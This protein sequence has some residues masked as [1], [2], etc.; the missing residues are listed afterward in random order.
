ML[1]VQNSVTVNVLDTPDVTNVNLSAT[2]VTSVVIDKDN[3]NTIKGG[4]TLKAYDAYGN[5]A[6]LVTKD[7]GSAIGIGVLSTG[8]K[9]T[10][11][12]NQTYS[13]DPTEL[14]VKLINGAYKSE[15]IAIE[16]DKRN[17]NLGRGFF[18]WRNNNKSPRLSSLMLPINQ[19]AMPLC[20]AAAPIPML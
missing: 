18:A 7:T 13:G 10:D 14:G 3:L 16:F 19:W 1:N 8:E 11:G 4:F 20:Q 12:A 17:Q 6:Q 5:A 15:K 2:I 9:I